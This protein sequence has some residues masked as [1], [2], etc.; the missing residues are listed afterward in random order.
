MSISR[1]FGVLGRTLAH[2]HSPALFADRFRDWGLSDASYERFERDN[3]DGL[4]QWLNE[5]A[6]ATPPLCGLNVTIPYKQAILPF[7]T[8]LTPAA[9]AIGAVNAIKPVDG[10]WMGHNTDAEGFMKSLR[11]FLRSSHERALILG[12]GGAAAAVR[13]GLQSLGIEVI[14]VTRTPVDWTAMRYEVLN[15]AF[16]RHCKLVVQCTPVGT[17]PD[18]DAYLDIPFDGL[19]AEHLVVDLVYNPAQTAFLARA[20]ASGAETLNG[21]PM[22]IAQAEAAWNW[23]NDG[24]SVA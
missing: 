8:K 22:L 2:S 1:R 5:A 21:K 20:A 3:L 4:D 14:H 9:E 18:V 19:T 7:L 24:S 6:N 16:L 10:G 13:H 17:Y 11:P 12:N 15:A 23:W